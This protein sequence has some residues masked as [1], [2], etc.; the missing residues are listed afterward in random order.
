MSCP[1]VKSSR[2]FIATKKIY[3][4]KIRN[5]GFIVSYQCYY[6]DNDT[7]IMYFISIELLNE[8]KNQKH[9]LNKKKEMFYFTLFKLSEKR[10]L[11]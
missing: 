3:C 10:C 5:F 11:N 6:S 4:S 8:K 9:Q 1:K 2:N 7:L